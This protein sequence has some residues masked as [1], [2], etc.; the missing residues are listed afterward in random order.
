MNSSCSLTNAC[1]KKKKKKR[2]IA[3][4]KCQTR[5]QTH[6]KSHRRMRRSLLQT[7]NGPK[8]LWGSVHTKL[9]LVTRLRKLKLPLLNC[10]CSKSSHFLNP[11]I[12]LGCTH[13]HLC[14]IDI[15]AYAKKEMDKLKHL[16]LWEVLSQRRAVAKGMGPNS[17]YG[18]YL[19]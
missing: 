3:K 11:F 17:I 6:L 13:L 12:F 7:S 14:K 16:R 8:G 15:S 4:T 2:K 18:G 9:P 19:L 10:C 5:N 1:T